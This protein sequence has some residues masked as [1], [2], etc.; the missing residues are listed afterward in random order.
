MNSNL[1]IP[2]NALNKAYQNTKIIRAEMNNFK[3]QMIRLI[4]TIDKKETEEFHKN[5]VISF[6]KKTFYDNNNFVNIKG[7]N[8]LVIHNGK[9]AKSSV[10]VIIEAKSP[11]NKTEM[12]TVNELNDK[13]LQELVLYYLRERI[14]N[15][16]TDLK[17]LVVTNIYEWFIFDAHIFEKLFAENKKLVKDFNDFEE[18][19]TSGKTTDYFYKEIAKPFI[20]T[21]K[22]DLVFAHFDIRKYEIPLRN[23]DIEDDKW[24]HDK[25]HFSKKKLNL[26]F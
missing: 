11:I 3:T 8:D 24:V 25:L 7:R 6:L 14:T 23:E 4:D 21:I 22:N 10:G 5:L 2:N 12:I 19:R 17:Q 26:V 13:A 16:N 1:L 9:D 15:K 20:E 18:K